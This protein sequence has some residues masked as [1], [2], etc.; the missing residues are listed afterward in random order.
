MKTT[1][2]TRDIVINRMQ[3]A[4]LLLAAVK[5]A[6]TD[7]LIELGKLPPFVSQKKA[8][9]TYGETNVK[10]WIKW[11]KVDKKKDGDKNCKVRLS[12]LELEAAAAAYN[13]CEYFLNL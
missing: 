5:T 1:K 8:Y 4:D 3:L 9:E 6:R 13:R 10:N 7:L 12:R 11:G 2:T